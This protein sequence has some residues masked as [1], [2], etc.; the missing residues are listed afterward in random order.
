MMLSG[1][2]N[3]FV[4][5]QELCAELRD[6]LHL[7]SEMFPVLEVEPHVRAVRL[8][9]YLLDFYQHGQVD[10]LELDNKIPHTEYWTLLEDFMFFLRALASVAKHR[11]HRARQRGE[12]TELGEEV[13][14]GAFEAISTQFEANFRAIRG[15]PL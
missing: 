11:Q 1:R 2:K 14:V 3:D 7:E 4:S 8:N 15:R 9:A 6:D 12:A 13:I 5:L 10:A